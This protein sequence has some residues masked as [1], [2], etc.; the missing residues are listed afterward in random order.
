MCLP[1]CREQSVGRSVLVLL[2]RQS[3][4]VG[5]KCPVHQYIEGVMQ[6][7]AVCSRQQYTEDEITR[8]CN[9]NFKCDWNWLL[10]VLLQSTAIVLRE[11]LYS[12]AA[13]T[14]GI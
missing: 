13:A 9:F 1:K 2:V 6:T 5:M 10:L 3:T 12:T 8:D 14:T 4:T 7:D 11:L